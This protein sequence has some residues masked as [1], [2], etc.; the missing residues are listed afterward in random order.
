M[1]VF[2]KYP[3]LTETPIQNTQS[4]PKYTTHSSNLQSKQ[5]K[6]IEQKT[7]ITVK[8]EIINCNT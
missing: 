7:G 2:W 3:P 8:A 4:P 1:A 6:G 5:K